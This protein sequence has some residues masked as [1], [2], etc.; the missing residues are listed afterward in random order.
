ML[1]QKKCKLCKKL[2]TPKTSFNTYCKPECA[3]AATKKRNKKKYSMA[4]TAVRSK[5]KKWAD[6]VK[7]RDNNFCV[8]CG[9]SDNLNSHHIY[10][11]SKKSTRLDVDNGITLC[12]YHHVFSPD[13]SAHKTPTDFTDWLREKKGNEFMDRLKKKANTLIY[14]LQ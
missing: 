1:K 9:T 10:S 13:F 5:D 14:D 2:F 3:F 6:A 4:R 7:E 8:Y 11:R 12:S